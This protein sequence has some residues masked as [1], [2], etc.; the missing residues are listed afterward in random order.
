[1]TD[2]VE[3]RVVARVVLSERHAATGA[4]R[5]Y[6]GPGG[7]PPE[8]PRPAELR[9]TTYGDDSY[10]LCYCDATGAEMTDTFHDT[11]EEA[12]AQAEREFS[13]HAGEWDFL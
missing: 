12:T 5:H 1:M 13:V 10:Y 6:V 7:G 9:I 8:M 11:V 3:P 4:T 2:A